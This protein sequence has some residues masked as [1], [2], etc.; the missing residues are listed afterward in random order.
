[1]KEM[2]QIDMTRR[3]AWQIY[4]ANAKHPKPVEKW[5]PLDSDKIRNG[6]VV[7]MDLTERHKKR[8]AQ[9]QAQDILKRKLPVY[10]RVANG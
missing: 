8:K 2:K 6:K 5:W 4:W 9:L 1:M 3:I 10:Q 7:N